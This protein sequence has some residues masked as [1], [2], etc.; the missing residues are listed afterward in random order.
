MRGPGY[1]CYGEKEEGTDKEKLANS[2]GKYEA[3]LG[4]W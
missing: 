1:I 2:A 4:Q 3:R